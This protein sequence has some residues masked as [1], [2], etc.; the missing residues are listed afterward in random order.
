MLLLS[1]S[2]SRLLRTFCCPHLSRLAGTCNVKF[3]APMGFAEAAV[4]ENVIAGNVMGRHAS[5]MY[6]NLLPKG[7]GGQIETAAFAKQ[8]PRHSRRD[9]RPTS[10]EKTGQKVVLDG[11][12]MT[13]ILAP[14]SEAPSECLFHLPRQSAVCAPKDATHTMH[15]LYTLRARGQVP[16]RVE[17][18]KYLPKALDIFGAEMEV[19]FASPH[20]QTWD[21]EHCGVFLASQRDLFRFI[22][23]QTLQVANQG[24]TPLDI[25]EQIKLPESLDRG[26]WRNRGYYGSLYHNARA[27]YG[28]YLCWFAGVPP[29]LHSLPPTEAGKRY[30][31]STSMKLSDAANVPTRSKPEDRRGRERRTGKLSQRSN[32][33]VRACYARKGQMRLETESSRETKSHAL[34]A[35]Y[36]R[37]DRLSFEDNKKSH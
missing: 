20:W 28:F 23:D 8:R 18:V 11:V 24:M 33:D 14:D 34:M 29:T 4:A 31:E 3:L 1:L 6:G 21:H 37:K 5:Y 10:C 36:A 12:E 16:R 35:G 27:Q 15:N 7:P 25:G 9:N 30:V 26:V 17:M 22:H 13:C 32:P 19:V 2:Y